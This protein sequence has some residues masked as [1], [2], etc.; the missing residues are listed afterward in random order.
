[1][2]PVVVKP[3]SFLEN[4]IQVER[5][6]LLYL[7]KL[8]DELQ[9]RMEELVD[10]KTA[11]SLTSEETAEMEAVAELIVIISY[12]NGMIASEAQKSNETRSW[13]QIIDQN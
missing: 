11:D 12:I 10:K 6:N 5:V 13:E 3:S 4:G 8:T 7:F 9:A 1:M 2:T